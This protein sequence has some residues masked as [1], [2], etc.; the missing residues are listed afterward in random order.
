MPVTICPCSQVARLH[1]HP[2]LWVIAVERINPYGVE[3]WANAGCAVI[4]PI[5]LHSAKASAVTTVLPAILAVR[6][7]SCANSYVT[8]VNLD[9]DRK[10]AVSVT[11]ID[12][13]G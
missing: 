11:Y 1:A 4:V 3:C 8:R 6:I 7:S 2:Y 9:K 13:S 10:R 5:C 12:A